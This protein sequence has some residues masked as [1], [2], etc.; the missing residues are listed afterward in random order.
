MRVLV[1][2]EY[3]ATVRDAFRARGFDAREID[4]FP[5]YAVTACGKV[6]SR[7][8]PT[9]PLSYFNLSAILSEANKLRG[10]AA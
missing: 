4:G 6:F 5:G 3:S 10:V 2:C 7:N 1:A 9:G 8:H